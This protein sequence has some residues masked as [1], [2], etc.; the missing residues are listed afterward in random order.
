M[1][2]PCEHLKWLV[3]AAQQIQIGP[4]QCPIGSTRLDKPDSCPQL[5]IAL[6]RPRVMLPMLVLDLSQLKENT[7]RVTAHSAIIHEAKEYMRTVCVASVQK[8]RVFPTPF[9]RD[10]PFDEQHAAVPA[11][12]LARCRVPLWCLSVQPPLRNSLLLKPYDSGTCI[13]VLKY[14]FS[15]VVYQIPRISQPCNAVTLQ[16]CDARPALCRRLIT[17][18]LKRV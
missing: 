1:E 15:H 16:E 11:E 14:R 5:R 10:N 13:L 17:N 18:P 2:C 12:E 3:E 8:V 9:H 4:S 6:G 7:V